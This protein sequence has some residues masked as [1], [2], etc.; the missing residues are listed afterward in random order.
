M[1]TQKL[2]R[3]TVSEVARI[4]QTNNMHICIGL[5]TG[6]FKFGW[7]IPPPEGKKRWNYIISKEK[8]EAETGIKIEKKG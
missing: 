6:I 3:L 5:R 8:F 7:A 1:K 4:M 2:E